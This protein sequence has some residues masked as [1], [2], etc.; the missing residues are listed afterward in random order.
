MNQLIVNMHNLC[1]RPEF[2]HVDKLGI[3][4]KNINATIK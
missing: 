1:W 3:P 2:E 4:D